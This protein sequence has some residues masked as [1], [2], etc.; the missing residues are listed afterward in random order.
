MKWFSGFVVY[1]LKAIYQRVLVAFGSSLLIRIHERGQPSCIS[2]SDCVKHIELG[3]SA[4][5]K[6]RFGNICTVLLF[7]LEL[8]RGFHHNFEKAKPKSKIFF[9]Q[10]HGTE[11][12]KIHGSPGAGQIPLSSATWVCFL[13]IRI[14]TI[15]KNYLCVKV[16]QFRKSFRELRLLFTILVASEQTVIKTM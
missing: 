10:F 2:N 15:F 5:G 12:K 11:V 16:R 4:L 9:S 8:G 13:Y 6:S 7:H 14:I 1:K 3:K